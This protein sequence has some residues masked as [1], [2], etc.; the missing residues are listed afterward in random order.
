MT[1]WVGHD[2]HVATTVILAKAG[3]SVEGEAAFVRKQRFPLPRE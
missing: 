1:W 3:I 2:R